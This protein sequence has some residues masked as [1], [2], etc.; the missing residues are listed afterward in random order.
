MS[1]QVTE[2]MHLLQVYVIHARSLLQHTIGCTLNIFIESNKIT[3]QRPQ[4]CKFSEV[5]FNQQNLQFFIIVTKNYTINRNGNVE[6]IE[7]AD[8]F[9]L[10]CFKGFRHGN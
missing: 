6:I 10:S 5:R 7:V 2:G 1:T 4:A 9:Y 3:Q 8:L